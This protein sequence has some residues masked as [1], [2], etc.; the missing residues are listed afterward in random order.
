MMT[1]FLILASPV[2]RRLPISHLILENVHAALY[3]WGMRRIS[4]LALLSLVGCSGRINIEPPIQSDF[5]KSRIFESTYDHIWIRTVDWFA[6]HNVVIE[7]IE[8]ESGLITAKYMLNMNEGELD[9]G[10]ITSSGLGCEEPSIKCAASLNIVIQSQGESKTKVTVNLFGRF[11]A[12]TY[13]GLLE[14]KGPIL[15]SGECMSTGKLERSIFAH[16]SKR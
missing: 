12:V 3:R 9:P 8:K 10:K 14:R 15:A 11:E 13:W 2:C 1:A 4:L 5:E 6:G 7:K 16:L